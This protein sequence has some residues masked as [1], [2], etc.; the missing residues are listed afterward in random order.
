ML[1][2][3]YLRTCFWLV[4]VTRLYIPPLCSLAVMLDYVHSHTVMCP[5][6]SL[7]RFYS[8]FQA[9]KVMQTFD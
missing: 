7:I 4:C 2:A 5:W 8:D 9:L 3:C 1:P 6:K